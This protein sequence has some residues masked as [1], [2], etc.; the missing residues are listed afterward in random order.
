MKQYT[1]RAN[2]SFTEHLHI[3]PRLDAAHIFPTSNTL[4]PLVQVEAGI[5]TLPVIS[6]DAAAGTSTPAPTM[7][8]TETRVK[9]ARVAR[10]LAEWSGLVNE[11]PRHFVDASTQSV[12]DKRVM[13]GSSTQT[14][15][16]P[17]GTSSTFTC[18][19]KSRVADGRPSRGTRTRLRRF[20]DSDHTVTLL[21]LSLRQNR[22]KY[23]CKWKSFVAAPET[24]RLSDQ[25]ST[26]IKSRKKFISNKKQTS[27][28]TPRSNFHRRSRCDAS[29]RRI[30]RC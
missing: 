21:P 6:T 9:I 27:Q 30:P 10:V 17:P 2:H 16:H 8:E 25:R 12:R 14:T 11:V 20:N 1:M 15:Y 26:S 19:F 29:L 5:Q 4:T 23:P 24:S 3:S 18:K 13:A 22:R 7:N 28:K